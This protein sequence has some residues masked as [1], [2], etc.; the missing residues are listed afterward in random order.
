MT[1]QYTVVE[2][3]SVASIKNE[4]TKKEPLTCSCP[5]TLTKHF[6]DFSIQNPRIHNTRHT[7]APP[8]YTSEKQNMPNLQ[9]VLVNSHP[10]KSSSD[11]ISQEPSTIIHTPLTT[12][13]K[14]Q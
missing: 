7:H 5:T 3:I 13:C 9:A 11:N 12:P 4:T 10:H 2:N 14:P 8:P 1:L 6:L